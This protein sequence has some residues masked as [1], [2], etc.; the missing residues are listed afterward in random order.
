MIDD[1]DELA[2]RAA[3]LD[4]LRSIGA[5]LRPLG[6]VLCLVGVLVLLWARYRGPGPLSPIGIGGIVVIAAGWGIFVYVLVARTRYV[7]RNPY[8]SGT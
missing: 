7:R 3:Y 8:D 2:R 1:P 6:F 4:R 5:R